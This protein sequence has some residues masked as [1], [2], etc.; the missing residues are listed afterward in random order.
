[1]WRLSRIWY[2]VLR[3]SLG[4]VNQQVML[5]INTLLDLFFLL[6]PSLSSQPLSVI[7]LRLLGDTRVKSLPRVIVFYLFLVRCVVQIWYLF[8]R[9]FFL[10][11]N[12]ALLQSKLIYYIQWNGQESKLQPVHCPV[13]S[14]LHAHHQTYRNVNCCIL[15]SDYCCYPTDVED[16]RPGCCECCCSSPSPFI[17]PAECTSICSLSFEELVVTDRLTAAVVTPGCSLQLSVKDRFIEHFP[18]TTQ[19]DLLMK[20]VIC[21][22]RSCT[23]IHHLAPGVGSSLHWLIG[24]IMFPTTLSLS[25]EQ[26]DKLQ[27]FWIQWQKIVTEFTLLDLL[28]M[29]SKQ[30]H[31]KMRWF[32][33]HHGACTIEFRFSHISYVINL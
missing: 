13:P 3:L 12:S 29:L 18:Q 15:L 4:S 6:G 19:L 27:E 16:M 33:P 9:L 21:F 1:M 31:D 14:Q 24:T 20:E 30:W 8:F 22:R 10:L 5:F 17:L 32:W 25:L 7:A 2:W 11:Y 23:F 26:Q 28:I